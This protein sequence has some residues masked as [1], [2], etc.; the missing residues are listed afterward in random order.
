MPPIQS[1]DTG[2]DIVVPTVRALLGIPAL[3]GIVD[4]F[5]KRRAFGRGS[6]VSS[7]YLMRFWPLNDGYGWGGRPYPSTSGR[8]SMPVRP[9]F[10]W[11]MRRSSRYP[12]SWPRQPPTNWLPPWRR[13]AQNQGFNQ[14]PP[15]PRWNGFGGTQ[16]YRH[17]RPSRQHPNGYVM[18]RP[19]L[20]VPQVPHRAYGA[21]HSPYS[22]SIG[23]DEY[24]MDDSEHQGCSHTDSESSWN[25]RPRHPRHRFG[26]RNY[27]SDS[28]YSDMSYRPHRTRGRRFG[29]DSDYESTSRAGQGLVNFPRLRRFNFGL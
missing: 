17:P 23:N 7:R 27:T 16:R 19:F 2:D 6:S 9:F 8:S 24:E 5:T 11:S 22:E 20:G 13:P 25:G 1:R 21:M 26:R 15:R 3:L 28:T 4:F 29:W 10:P 18:P 12:T 14:R